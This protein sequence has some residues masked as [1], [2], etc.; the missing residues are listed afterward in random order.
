MNRSRILNVLLL[1]LEILLLLLILIPLVFFS[2]RMIEGR[3]QDLANVGNEDYHSGIGL[4]LFLT[5]PLLFF[6]NAPLALI[7]VIGTRCARKRAA[8]TG[9]KHHVTLFRAITFSAMGSQLLY[10]VMTLVV[11]NVK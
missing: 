7:G 4:Y 2:Y 8:C 3:I 11:M 9:Q 6:W 5:H 1:L 10:F